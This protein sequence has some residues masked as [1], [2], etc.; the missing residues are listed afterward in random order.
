MAAFEPLPHERVA[1]SSGTPHRDFDSSNPPGYSGKGPSASPG[2]GGPGGSDNGCPPAY[3]PPGSGGPPGGSGPLGRNPGGEPSSGG[4]GGG[5]MH[6]G[7]PPG[8]ANPDIHPHNQGPP[9]IIHKIHPDCE[10]SLHLDPKI[11]LNMVSSWDGEH[12]H[13]AS[14][15]FLYR[16]TCQI[17]KQHRLGSGTLCAHQVYSIGR[18]LVEHARPAGSGHLLAILVLL[19]EGT[20]LAVLYSE[21]RE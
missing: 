6:R 1:G 5:G 10:P 19:E 3:S 13:T 18:L 21:L 8:I 9:I 15:L 2:G 14:I 17:G 11:P 12:G 16:L 20:A 4:P 7:D